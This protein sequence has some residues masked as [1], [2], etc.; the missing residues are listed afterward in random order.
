MGVVGGYRLSDS[1]K[2]NTPKSRREAVRALQ[3]TLSFPT[4]PFL[5]L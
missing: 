4:I 3:T 5:Y 1:G 2:S